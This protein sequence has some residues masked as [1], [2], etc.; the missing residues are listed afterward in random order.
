VD[1]YAALLAT[2]D[3][4]AITGTADP[5]MAKIRLAVLDVAD[6]NGN[7]GTNQKFDE[8]DIQRFYD[9]L[10]ME[11]FTYTPTDPDYSHYDL[12]GDGY[13][14]GSRTNRFDLN[15]NFDL[16]KGLT[17]E[18]DT[19][20]E[21]EGDT[22]HFNENSVSDK[23]I[24]CFYAY[25]ELF[26][27]NEEERDTLLGNSW[28]SSLVAQPDS[29]VC[30]LPPG[31]CNESFGIGDWTPPPLHFE[32]LGPGSIISVDVE[33]SLQQLSFIL[34]ATLSKSAEQVD[35]GYAYAWIPLWYYA[36][37]DGTLKFELDP[38]WV[39]QHLNA[40]TTLRLS[41]AIFD[42]DI[43]PS[44]WSDYLYVQCTYDTVDGIESIDCLKYDY[45]DP[46]QTVTPVNA[47]FEIP[48]ESHKYYGIGVE[49]ASG[50]HL[51]VDT[52]LFS[53]DGVAASLILK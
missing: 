9:G 28:C 29:R 23:D 48:V 10:N 52:K 14:G 7:L 33:G 21:I 47:F 24:L 45:P 39:N 5:S 6:G 30:S 42:E 41:V 46:S 1:A 13:T 35:Y 12:N 37:R 2:D 34:N 11:D 44:G 20:M 49:L 36:P 32:H 4:M 43:G 16:V 31:A 26:D 38:N 25:S 27:G 22:E 40:Y 8:H 18:N 51:G 19:T 53:A 17:F 50:V 3:G 15:A